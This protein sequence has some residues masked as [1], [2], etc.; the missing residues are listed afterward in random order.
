MDIWKLEQGAEK[1]GAESKA[2]AKTP[3]LQRS[4][5]GLHAM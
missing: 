1:P 2:Q 5:G 4:I 3:T